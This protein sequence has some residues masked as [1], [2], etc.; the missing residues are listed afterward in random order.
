MFQRVKFD[1]GKLLVPVFKEMDQSFLLTLVKS[2]ESEV[3]PAVLRCLSNRDLLDDL[4]AND[5]SW[6]VQEEAKRVIDSRHKRP[7]CG[8]RWR[9]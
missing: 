4:S 7:S 5:P 1:V 6:K 9:P 3:R 8:S 2:S